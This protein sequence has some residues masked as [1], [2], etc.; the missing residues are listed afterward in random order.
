[1]E[2]PG[3]ARTSPAATQARAS[4]PPA[5]WPARCAWHTAFAI[6]ARP[7]QRATRS[8]KADHE[9]SSIV[10]SS[11]LRPLQAI[12]CVPHK[13]ART[14]AGRGGRSGVPPKAFS[15][16]L[17]GIVRPGT[18]AFDWA[19]AEPRVAPRWRAGCQPVHRCL[20]I[21]PPRQRGGLSGLP[22]LALRCVRPIRAVRQPEP[23]VDLNGGM[24]CSDFE[25]A[26]WIS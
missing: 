13:N 26:F 11:L 1:M 24:T 4:T 15:S 16:C 9:P 8:P 2:T 23:A 19:A 25:S 22:A 14:L 18:A 10:P 7:R 21:R 3:N 12:L 5:R 6:R 17:H 20:S